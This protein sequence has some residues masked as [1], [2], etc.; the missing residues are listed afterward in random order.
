MH[1]LWLLNN[2]FFSGNE[3]TKKINFGDEEVSLLI[4]NY[5]KSKALK[6]PFDD[7]IHKK[8][9]N[10]LMMQ[11]YSPNPL[12][13][14]Y[15]LTPN[16]IQRDQDTNDILQRFELSL[17]LVYYPQ[18]QISHIAS[19]IPK[20]A[21][22][23]P[24]WDSYNSVTYS[25]KNQI[26]EDTFD[27]VIRYFNILK[28]K[29]LKYSESLDQILRIANIGD[30]L[31]E[32][33][34]LW[35]FIEGFWNPDPS[36]DSKLDQSLLNMLV[37]DYAPGKNR[38]DPEINVITSAILSQNEKIGARKYSELRNI[39]AHGQFLNIQNAWTADQW[40]II[41]EQRNLLIEI[42]IESLMNYIERTA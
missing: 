29:N 42:I 2:I 26:N 9:V 11:A 8:I 28:A 31:T 12:D 25:S 34:S 14:V 23:I 33:L 40:K 22:S 4:T 13:S 39:L 5:E 18:T 10:I 38:R 41:Y 3:F 27:L 21:I 1:A 15:I 32:L 24:T 37:T 36:R 6:T 30:H 35:S 20:A 7:W 16:E 19:H 17:R